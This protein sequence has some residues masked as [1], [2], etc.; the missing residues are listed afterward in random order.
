V[1][2]FTVR[3][4]RSRD[5]ITAVITGELDMANVEKLV[6]E[7]EGITGPVCFDCSR[8]TFVRRSTCTVRP[9][10]VQSP[11]KLAV[12]GNFVTSPMNSM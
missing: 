6:A 4:D 1:D 2:E 7:L 9:A 11:A 5:P 8:L 12:V 3:V 10:T